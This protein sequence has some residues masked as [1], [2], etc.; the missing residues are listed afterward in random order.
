[1]LLQTRGIEIDI[2]ALEEELAAPVIPTIAIRNKG[3]REILNKVSEAIYSNKKTD[4]EREKL[5]EDEL[6]K[7]SEDI[8]KKVQK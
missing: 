8:A 3:L 6:W 5:T 7:R 2:E 1:M 4:E